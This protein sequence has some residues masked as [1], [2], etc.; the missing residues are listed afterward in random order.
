MRNALGIRPG[1]KVEFKLETGNVLK[2]RVKR[3]KPSK[4]IAA[5]FE[6]FDVSA[7]RT[8]TKDD[9]VGAVRESRWDEI[10]L[11]EG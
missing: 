8:E 1:D 4:T 5:I 7:L 10:L 6:Q 2:L 9:A 11:L 3:P